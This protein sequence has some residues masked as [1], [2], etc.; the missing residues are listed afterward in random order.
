MKEI[1]EG[2]YLIKEKG[3]FG[4]IKPSENVYVLAGKNGLIFDAGY[5]TRSA[6]RFLL[7]EIR[8]IRSKYR[9]QGRGFKLTRVLPSHIHPDHFSG[10]KDLRKKLGVK[11][12]LTEKMSR[13]IKN[14]ENFYKSFEDTEYNNLPSSSKIGSNLRHQLLKKFYRTFYRYGY[15]INYIP[16]PDKLIN[17]ETE[18]EINE[19]RW[20][21]FPSPGHAT[22]HVSLYNKK[23]GILFS[24]DNILPATITWL[25]PP[26]SDVREYMDSLQRIYNL[27]NLNLALP[28][29]GPPIRNPKERIAQILNHRNKRTNQ[30][31]EI[32][33]DNPKGINTPKIV[34]NLYP[35][36]R[37]FFAGV[38]RG[39]IDLTLRMLEHQEH[40]KSVIINNSLFY[41]PNF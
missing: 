41:V 40:V 33:Q 17:E 19:E 35:G 8:M 3:G 36:A 7:K 25:G 24:G 38:A 12:I 1:V 20:K 27:K 4:V 6:I 15:G 32:V 13:M 21:I 5:G 23:K 39:W 14:K 18:I 34:Y 31:L 22:D 2:I 16:D 9:H 37:K 29:H 28:A 30:V 26:S 11:I 10:L